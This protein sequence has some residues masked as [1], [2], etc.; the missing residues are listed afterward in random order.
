MPD[1]RLLLSPS[2]A[3]ARDFHIREVSKQ[4]VFLI[5]FD[6]WTCSLCDMPSLKRMF[7]CTSAR[8]LF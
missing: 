5:S 6:S 8:A 3:R 7:S 2:N 1:R 4:Q